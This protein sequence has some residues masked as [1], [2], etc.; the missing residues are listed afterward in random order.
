MDLEQLL[1]IN[2]KQLIVRYA[3]YA[4]D[5]LLSV[6]ARDISADSLRSYLLGLTAFQS[7]HKRH[8]RLLSAVKD[9][10]DEADT[11]NKIFD[12]LSCNCA[13]YINY[14]IFQSIADEY[15]IKEG[16]H[17]AK[18]DYPDHLGHYVD[19]HKISE[20]IAV[21]SPLKMYNEG[22][23]KLILKVSIEQTRKLTEVFKLQTAVADILG[24]KAIA[25]LFFHVKKKECVVVTFLIPADAADILF[26]SDNQFVPKD[27]ED[28]RSQ[29]VTC[30][31][32]NG[33]KY[34]FTKHAL[35]EDNLQSMTTS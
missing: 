7:G 19:M 25:L 26:V 2:L 5:I 15:D 24:L 12:L 27:I 29:S 20:F 14:Q 10:L 28:F 3:F 17:Q 31:E 6:Q 33:Y 9:N 34:D 1:E 4:H 21:R 11:I 32:C 13:S 23:T 8:S 30:L 18:L 22:L 16:E 35:M